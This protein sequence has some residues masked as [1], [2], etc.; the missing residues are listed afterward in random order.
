M[1]NNIT[2]D[3]VKAKQMVLLLAGFYGPL[4]PEGRERDAQIAREVDG[5]PQ[6]RTDAAMRNAIAAIKRTT[7]P[8][9]ADE[10]ASLLDAVNTIRAFKGQ[11]AVT[12]EQAAASVAPARAAAV[13]EPIP[14]LKINAVAKPSNPFRKTTSQ[15]HTYVVQQ[16]GTKI[17]VLETTADA[18]IAANPNEMGAGK[19]FASLCKA[20]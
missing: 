12:L 4:K 5:N 7:N 1:A 11:P 10:K 2:T 3:Q 18:W 20:L 19:T 15:H 16:V 8:L 6:G 13:R 9:S 17:A 14:V